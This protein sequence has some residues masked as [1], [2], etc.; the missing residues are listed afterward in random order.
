MEI[1]AEAFLSSGLKSIVV[2]KSVVSIGERAF[3]VCN[4]LTAIKL[5]DTLT[6]IGNDAFDNDSDLKVTYSGTES[7]F[8]S[9]YKSYMQNSQ[10]NSYN[11]GQ[12]QNQRFN[13]VCERE[14]EVILHRIWV[15]GNVLALL[16]MIVG[17]VI[18][19]VSVPNGLHWAIAG[20]SS[21][22]VNMII[23]I[24]TRYHGDTD[25][26]MQFIFNIIELV[27]CL[28]LLPCAFATT[29]TLIYMIALAGGMLIATIYIKIAEDSSIAWMFICFQIAMLFIPISILTWSILGLA[30]PLLLAAII[31]VIC[32]FYALSDY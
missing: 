23:A 9:V 6:K 15:G 14:P 5:F 19:A 30:I 20:F 26:G 1:G 31:A 12:S 25:E 4:S 21:I 17:A 2:P 13:L 3:G 28:V 24:I 7:E 16:A 32:G 11:Y 27:A 10:Y 29:N 18:L 22:V 8:V